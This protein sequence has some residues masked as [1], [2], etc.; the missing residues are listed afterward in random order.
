VVEAELLACVNGLKHAEKLPQQPI[1]LETDCALA[2][3]SISEQ[4]TNRSECWTL[5]REITERR[6]SFLQIQFEKNSRSGNGVAHSLAQLGKHESNGCLRGS[7]PSCV[8]A[9]IAK[10]CKN[11]I[12]K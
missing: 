8:S 6:E 10:D 11:V 9:M 7:S 2:F 12:I 4:A 5:I 1:I 3:H